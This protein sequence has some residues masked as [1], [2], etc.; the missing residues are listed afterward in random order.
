MDKSIYL[1]VEIM[2]ELKTMRDNLE[3][4]LNK[5]NAYVEKNEHNAKL[6]LYISA[7]D[8]ELQTEINNFLKLESLVYKRITPKAA[9]QDL[10]PETFFKHYATPEEKEAFRQLNII[11]ASKLDNT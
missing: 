2:L 6:K 8:E 5:W 9:K 1:D 7:G 10:P 11:R 4:R 3:K